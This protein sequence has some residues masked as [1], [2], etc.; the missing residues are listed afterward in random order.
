VPETN[1]THLGDGLYAAFDGWGIALSVND[2]RNPPVAYIDG[3]SV[4]AALNRFWEQ[5]TAQERGR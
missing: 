5:Q 4:M 2:H 1:V 3:P